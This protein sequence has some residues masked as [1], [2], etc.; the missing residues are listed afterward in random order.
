LFISH[1]AVI[2]LDIAADAWAIQ[3]SEKE[4]R[5][6]I[7]AAMTAGLF[8][9]MAFGTS[10]L[11]YIA[12]NFSF[13]LAFITG[14]IITISTIILP[15]I[16]KENIIY[17]KRPKIMALIFFELKKKQTLLIAIFGL[18]TSMNFGLL[19]LIIPEYM[20]NVLR[21]DVAQSGLITSL[22]PIG[23]IIGASVGGVLAD[24]WGRKKTLYI[25]LIPLIFISASLLY[26]NSWQI[27]AIIYPIIGFLQ[28]GSAF[29]A[30][31]SLFMD[32]TNPKIGASQFSIL[33]S[34]ANF[35]DIGIAMISGSVLLM[36]GYHRFFLLAAW[37]VGPA[38]LILYFIKEKAK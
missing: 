20:M 12:K 30:M 14:G 32:I 8:G 25:Y 7:S 38:L 16:I 13:N 35:G 9:G 4:E 6:K 33:T 5:G 10:T 36:L 22:F 37:I 24:K 28:G 17:K 21:L 19:L 2:L 26:A 23:T 34:I 11:S 15:M 29:A 27:L 31:F 1:I 3:I 18:V